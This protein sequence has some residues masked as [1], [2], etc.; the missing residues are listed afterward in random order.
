MRMTSVISSVL[1]LIARTLNLGSEVGSNISA[2]SAL[3]RTRLGFRQ[4]LRIWEVCGEEDLLQEWGFILLGEP[5]MFERH[6]ISIFDLELSFVFSALRSAVPYSEPPSLGTRIYIPWAFV[7]GR[8][9][10]L[11]TYTHSSIETQKTL[12]L[13]FDLKTGTPR[14]RRK[15]KG[16]PGKMVN[17]TYH[18][19]KSVEYISERLGTGK[20]EGSQ[21]FLPLN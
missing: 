16:K 2:S 14:K 19:A 6:L 4:L 12:L 5:F 8:E 20:F 1:V 15:D 13:E 21:C 11:Y 7:L 17:L 9:R 10:L 18:L 3:L